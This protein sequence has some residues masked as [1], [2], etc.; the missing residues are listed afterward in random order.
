M[1]LRD[2][3]RTSSTATSGGSTTTGFPGPAPLPRAAAPAA[4]A[5]ATCCGWDP[6]GDLVLSSHWTEQP[7]ELV[8]AVSGTVT[9]LGSARR[10]PSQTAA[11]ARRGHQPEYLHATPTIAAGRTGGWVVACQGARDPASRRRVDPRRACAHRSRESTSLDACDPALPCRW[12]RRSVGRSGEGCYPGAED[13]QAAGDVLDLV[14]LDRAGRVSQRGLED[15][16]GPGRVDV[17]ELRM[18]LPAIWAAVRSRSPR[19]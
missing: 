1:T 9:R 3:R 17:L 10:T 8:R 11:A 5:A 13:L 18:G 7:L 4:T 6:A 14:V 12:A 19:A 16:D 15:L 2:G